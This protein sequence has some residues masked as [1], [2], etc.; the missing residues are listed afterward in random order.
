MV[1]IS[2]HVNRVIMASIHY[3]N[4]QLLFHWIMS[5]RNR[6]K[7]HETARKLKQQKNACLTAIRMGAYI[8]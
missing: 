3:R 2:E 6:E 5:D 7:Y 8:N 1:T 4:R